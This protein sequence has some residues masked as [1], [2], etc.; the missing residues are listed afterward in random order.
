M[1][2]GDMKFSKI[3]V[4][5]VLFSMIA[6]AS[7]RQTGFSIQL[8]KMEIDIQEIREL[9]LDKLEG[10]PLISESDIISYDKKSHSLI[11]APVACERISGL[12]DEPIVLICVDN[13]PVYWALLWDPGLSVSN[14]WTVILKDRSWKSGKCTV[15]VQCGYPTVEWF[16][17]VD[18]RDDPRI[19]GALRAAGKLKED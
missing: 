10:V 12:E 13:R 17:G 7:I 2:G 8:P 9:E 19:L 18:L 15:Q 5:V 14:G 1:K 16:R 11:L 4:P 6:S 3:A